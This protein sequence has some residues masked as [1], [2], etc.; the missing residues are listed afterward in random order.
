M[1]WNPESD[2]VVYFKDGRNTVD[3]AFQVIPDTDP[4]PFQNPGF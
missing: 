1:V 3:T 2:Q 4:D